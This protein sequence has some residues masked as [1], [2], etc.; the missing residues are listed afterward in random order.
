VL[1]FVAFLCVFAGVLFGALPGFVASR[2]RLNVLTS[3]GDRS[4]GSGGVTRAR[5]VLVAV[6]VTLS[7]VLLMCA[8]LMLQSLHKL[9]SVD[10]GFRTANVLSMRISL[11][12]TKYGKRTELNQFF[13]QVL[14][15]V[16][17][18]P[19]VENAAVSV[20][21][22]LN[23]DMGSM[24]GGVLLEGRPVNPNELSPQVNFELASPDYFRVLGVPVLSGRPFT[25]GD[26]EK[27]P[28]VA[29]V[30]A[31]MAKHYW[32]TGSPIGRHV[33]TDSGKTWITVVGVVSDVHQYG[34]DKDSKDG[35]YLPQDQSPSLTDAHLL[36]RTRVDPMRTSNQIA[37]VIHQIDSRQP[38]TDVRTLDQLRSAQLGTPRVTA[39][40]LGL[41]AT[42]AL[43]ITVVG[44]S[45]TLALA[46][47]H[48]TKEIGIRIA[49]GAPKE[50]I[51]RNVLV[52]GMAPVIAGIAVGVVAALFSTRLLTSMLFAVKP[53]D[54]FTF[55]SIAI[56]LISVALLGCSIPARRAIGVD[57]MKALR[58]E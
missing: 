37:D 50:E 38:V 20:M 8:G 2:D 23:S 1:L 14:G 32:P 34:L 15:R 41:F 46:V 51:L 29:I 42:L 5:Q 12:W 11:D 10:P 28:A 36:V 27:A 16:N 26:T 13:H 18:L 24:S 22:P 53:N 39:I 25:D 40:L 52:R 3:S 21:V 54:P 30:N 55:A 56:L 45:G 49:L 35:I 4:V 33:S 58:T 19:G 47:A 17:G 7:F 43:F 31:R 44:V 48:R 57:P 9:L 6:Q